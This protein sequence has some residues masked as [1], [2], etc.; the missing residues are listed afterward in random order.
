MLLL[1]LLVT[2]G[3]ALMSSSLNEN[4]V[5]VND[6][7]AQ[8]ALGAAEAGIAH[9]RAQIASTLGSTSL[10]SRLTGATGS[11]PYVQLSPQ[12]PSSSSDTNYFKSNDRVVTF[13]DGGKASYTITISNNTA[14][15]NKNPGYAA[16]ASETTDADRRI[17]IKSVGTYKNAS[18]TIRVLV[19]F[20]TVNL[21]DPPGAITLVDGGAATTASFTGNAFQIRGADSAAATATTSPCDGAPSTTNPKYAISTNSDAS[22][23]EIQ[24]SVTYNSSS[25]AA[26]QTDNIWG[27][28]NGTYD[29]GTGTWTA[30]NTPTGSWSNNN[31]GSITGG[32]LASFASAMMPYATA[33]PA[34]GTGCTGT[35]CSG[36]LGSSASPGIFVASSNMKFN[37]SGKGYGVLIVT[38]DLELAGNYNWEGLILV[39]GNGS[40][41]VGGTFADAGSA[42]LKVYGAIM[43]ADTTGGA[44]NLEVRGNAGVTYSSQALCRVQQALSSPK[45]T[46]IA[47]EQTD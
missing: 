38:A 8:R 47:W 30:S 28:G 2:L 20:S 3:V 4:V 24:S 34:S 31:G 16:E 1:T 45:S 22:S 39:V 15:Y 10:T 36:N 17:W 19:D 21:F 23:T 13:S 33:I 6:M 41:K 46:I 7:Y 43:V 12:D 14:A 25:A 37:G 35:P 44:T 29:S 40:V 9:A 32:M 27:Q 5:S 26:S 18:R 42:G 11:V